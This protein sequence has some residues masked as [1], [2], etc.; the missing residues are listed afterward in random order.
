[1]RSALL[2]LLSEFVMACAGAPSTAP[3]RPT[4]LLT[5]EEAVGRAEEFVRVNGY[6][7]REDADPRRLQ[8][9]RSLTYGTTPEELLPQR[10]GTL[11]PKACGVMKEAALRFDRGWS[12][13]F[14]YNPAHPVWREGDDEWKKS[15]RSRS[16]VVI[17]D[18]YGSD[19]FV[20]HMDFSVTGE[21][22]KRLPGM[23]ELDRLLGEAAQPGIAADP[24]APG[25]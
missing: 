8:V 13:V 19:V 15:I 3:R 4:H 2:I 7:R 25:R 5:E 18:E 1:M 16:R 22:I 14:C 21:G 23:N 20:P 9:E 24:A 11:L 6:V 17:M 10:E 12:V